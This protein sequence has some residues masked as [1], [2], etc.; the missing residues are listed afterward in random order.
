MKEKFLHLLQELRYFIAVISALE[1]MV[2]NNPVYK[3]SNNTE[4][5]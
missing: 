1:P 4:P 5:L 3:S 2:L